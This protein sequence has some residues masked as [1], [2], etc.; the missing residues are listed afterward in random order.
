VKKGMPHTH[1]RA[2]NGGI[3]IPQF[4]VPKVVVEMVPEARAIDV[5]HSGR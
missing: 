3:K 1:G 2:V 5:V 4:I